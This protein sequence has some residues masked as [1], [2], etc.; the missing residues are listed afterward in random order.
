VMI[1]AAALKSARAEL[2]PARRG[3]IRLNTDPVRPN[4]VKVV[5]DEILTL[6][7]EFTNP[8]QQARYQAETTKRAA[9]Y[10]QTAI[11]TLVARLD[12]MLILTTAQRG[13]LLEMFESNWNDEW[14]AGTL[15]MLWDDSAPFPAIPNRLIV[16]LLSASQQ[17]RWTSLEI[18]AIDATEAY[19]TYVSEIMDGVRSEFA[20]GLD[21]ARPGP[22]KP[23]AAQPGP[24]LKNEKLKEL[25]R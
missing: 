22:A 7:K 14:G 17:K 23:G 13:R 8:A 25:P 18:T 15:S 5:R 12:R 1:E 16:P 20:D 9:T 19:I 11:H 24:E 4:G 10:R 21:G 3:G 6:V 2:A